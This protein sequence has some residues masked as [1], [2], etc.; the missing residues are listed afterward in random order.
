MPVS[1]ST[2]NKT[3]TELGQARRPLLPS[4]KRTSAVEASTKEYNKS[5][6]N[7]AVSYKPMEYH[8]NKRRS[9]YEV[10]DANSR[11]MI[12]NI[13]SHSVSGSNVCEQG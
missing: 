13:Q 10:D 9:F 5:R 12:Q 7:K 11:N 6:R 3:L 4:V 2:A 8:P 1:V